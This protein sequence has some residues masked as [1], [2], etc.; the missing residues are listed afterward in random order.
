MTI[1]TEMLEKL[2]TRKAGVHMVTRLP[3]KSAE[4]NVALMNRVGLPVPASL[5]KTPVQGQ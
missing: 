1:P 5:K 2:A 3:K 4:V